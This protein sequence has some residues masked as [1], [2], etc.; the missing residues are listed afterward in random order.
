MQHM[1]DFLSV[2][3]E[4]VFGRAKDSLFLTRRFVPTV[5]YIFNNREFTFPFNYDA[6][7]EIGREILSAKKG[8]SDIGVGSFVV[9]A[10]IIMAERAVVAAHRKQDKKGFPQQMAQV[11][12]QIQPQI[13]IVST[14]VP[15]SPKISD[16][17]SVV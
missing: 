11:I 6:I 8:S 17:K 9:C 13:L 4:R 1:H 3:V 5:T 12:Q 7:V 14:M 2:R 10:A 16:R 15:D